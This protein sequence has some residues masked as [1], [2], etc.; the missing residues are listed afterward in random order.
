MEIKFLN[1]RDNGME[2]KAKTKYKNFHKEHQHRRPQ[3][4]RYV[5][6]HGIGVFLMG[7]DIT[8]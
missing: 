5:D 2:Q 1:C 6:G 4:L 8:L 3:T 7:Y